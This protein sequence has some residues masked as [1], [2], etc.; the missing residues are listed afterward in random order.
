MKNDVKKIPP[1]REFYSCLEEMKDLYQNQGFVIAK[2]LFEEMKNRYNWMM[3]YKTFTIYFNKEF[4]VK[5][6]NITQTDDQN[7]AT[8]TEYNESK[9]KVAAPNPNIKEKFKPD[10]KLLELAGKMNEINKM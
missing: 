7:I 8:S 5:T 4:K 6:A 3:S 1:R 2:D 10:P 9:S